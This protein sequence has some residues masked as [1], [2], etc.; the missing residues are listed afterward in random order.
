MLVHNSSCSTFGLKDA[1][2]VPGVYTITMMGGGMLL[3]RRGGSLMRADYSVPNW[4][5]EGPVDER[6]LGRKFQSGA[7][8]GLFLRVGGGARL[9]RLDF[10]SSLQG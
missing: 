7:F 6:E 2:T 10:L 3:N 5:T 9:G 8:N 1:P 4:R